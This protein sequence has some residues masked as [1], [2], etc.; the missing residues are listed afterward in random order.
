MVSPRGTRD[1]NDHIH[2]KIT[3]QERLNNILFVKSAVVDKNTA[4]NCLQYCVS[5]VA[6]KDKRVSRCYVILS[7]ELAVAID[8]KG[9]K[10]GHR[11][12]A[13][14]LGIS[15]GSSWHLRVDRRMGRS[16]MLGI[17]LTVY[18]CDEGS[19]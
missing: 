3:I 11:R 6:A 18:R 8:G 14:F 5:N 15:Q 19:R 13:R 1:A 2:S 17:V 4:Y 16:G 9:S 10:W 7:E 12:S